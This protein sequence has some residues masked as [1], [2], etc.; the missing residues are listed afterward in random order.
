MKKGKPTPNNKHTTPQNR[1]AVPNIKNQ[2]TKNQ[3][4]ANQNAKNKNATKPNSASTNRSIT[5]TRP[6]TATQGSKSRSPQVP[7]ATVAQ[8]G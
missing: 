8:G 5:T 6:A 4:T 2:G 3:R 1:A 7:A